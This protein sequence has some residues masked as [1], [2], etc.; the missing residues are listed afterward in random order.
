MAHQLDADDDGRSAKFNVARYLEITGQLSAQLLSTA[1]Q[2]G[3]ASAD[4]I[5]AKFSVNHD[6]QLPRQLFSA[7][8]P[9]DLELIDLRP[10]AEQ[11]NANPLAAAEKLMAADLAVPV[12]LTEDVLYRQLLIRLADDHWIWYQ[13]FH[14]M[15]L[16]G[17]SFTTLTGRICGIYR[18]LADGR[19]PT[20]SA[21][22]SFA[23]LVAA[24][25]EYRGSADEEADATFWRNYCTGLPAPL[26]VA[27]VLGLSGTTTNET[28]SHK[29][30]L[31]LSQDAAARLDSLA[32]SNRLNWT[33]LLSAAIAEFLARMADQA[34]IV[35]GV[36]MMG[37]IGRTATERAALRST[38]PVVTV[39]PLRLAMTD[40]SLPSRA[41]E[42]AL[43][44][45]GIKNHWR[46][47]SEQ[48]QRDAGLTG[49]AD[50]GLYGPVL[51]LKIFDYQVDFGTATGKTHHLSAGPIEELE[52][53]IY[54][55]DGQIE[56][57][58]EA[59]GSKYSALDTQNLAERLS[60]WLES[61]AAGN[62]QF[63]SPEEATQLTVW[64][65]GAARS[66]EL[67][68]VV[69]LFAQ[70]ARTSHA[71]PALSAAG[72]TLTFG[73]LAERANKLARVLIARGVGAESVVAVALPR[74]VDSVVSIMAVHA[75]G[76]AILPLDLE[77]PSDRLGY[78]LDDAAPVALISTSSVELPFAG[79]RIDLDALNFAILNGQEIQPEERLSP[80]LPEHLAYV[81]YTSG[82]TGKP[83]GVLSTH[84]GLRNLLEHHRHDQYERTAAAL[85]SGAQNR[86][87]R[88]LH[89]ASMSFDSAWDQLL[90]LYLGHEVFICDDESRR[91][92]AALV[93]LIRAERLDSL[94]VTP[95]F[96]SQLID[97]GL[98]ERGEHHPALVAFGGEAASPSIWAALR[99]QAD[100]GTH[101]HNYYGPTEYSVDS[102]GAGVEQADEPVVGLPLSNTD[103]YVLDRK[104]RAV[105][106]GVP[107]E[108][109]IAGPGLA[110]GYH[111][112]FG[113]TA[114]RFIANPF[115]AEPGSRMYR[116]GD[117]ARWRA[118][119]L[120]DYLSRADDQ[121]KIRG[122]RVEPG[123]VEAAIDAL[124]GILSA[125]V[126]AEKTGS[127][128]RLVGFAVLANAELAGDSIR[129]AL[130][131][132]L[133][134]YLIP[135]V[136]HVIDSM[137]LTVNGKIDRAALPA[138]AV[139]AAPTQSRAA[140]GRAAAN[141]Q[142]AMLCQAVSD[143]VRI[144]QVSPDDD[145]FALG[146][147]SISAMSL[148]GAARR[149]G[150]LL[151]PRQ[152]FELRTAA[153]M[154]VELQPLPDRQPSIPAAGDTPVL[155]I[156]AWYLEELVEAVYAQG[157]CLAVPEEATPELLGQ[158]LDAVRTA[159]PALAASLANGILQVPEQVTPLVVHPVS[160]AQDPA[161]T[162]R[163][164]AEQLDPASGRMLAA[165]LLSGS[166]NG[167]SS[168]MLLLAAHHLVVDGVSWRVILPELEAAY[169]ALLA[170]TTP[171][172]AA[173][174]TSLRAWSAELRSQDHQAELPFWHTQ[175]QTPAGS[176]GRIDARI[177]RHG[178]AGQQRILL[179]SAS[180]AALL[181]MVPARFNCTVDESLLAAV[182]MAMRQLR[183]VDSL[184]L[185]RETHGRHA[186]LDLERT[187]GWLTSE[188]P[189]HLPLA[190]DPRDAV[191][192]VK[193]AIR[194]V[195]A[196]GL[197]WGLLR[198]GGTGEELAQLQ[199]NNPASLL[200]NYLGRFDSAAAGSE[201][202]FQP[203][204]GIF[205]DAFAVHL[206]PAAPLQHP[207]ELNAFL[208]ESGPEAQL[209]LSWTW[210]SGLL[211]EADITALSAG[212]ALAAQQLLAEK[213]PELSFVP[214]D[215]AVPV[216][217]AQVQQLEQR[218]G[219]L[220][221]VLPLT[222]LHEGLLYQSSVE[223]S[224][225]ASVTVLELSGE[226][227]ADRLKA[228]LHQVLHRYPQLGAV[229]STELDQLAQIIPADPGEISWQV[230]TGQETDLAALEA[231]ETDRHF[232]PSSGPLLAATLL[233]TEVSHAF[234]LLTTHHLL[235]DGWSTPIIVEALLAAYRDDLPAGNGLPDYA[236]ALA[237]V[238]VTDTDRQAWA[239]ALDD[240]TPTMV[241][242]ETTSPVD[243]LPVAELSVRLPEELYTDLIA[244]ARER[245][246]TMNAIAQLGFAAAL[247]TLSG[248]L[249][250][251]FG[252]TVSGRDADNAA[253]KVVG[254]FTNTVPVRIAV[255]A[256]APLAAQLTR[257]QGEQ[258][259]LRD[260]S[261]LGLADIQALGGAGTLFDTLFVME[262][263]PD[264]P[265]S[266]ST[267]L[268]LTSV[269]NRGYTHYPLTVLMLPETN[270]FRLVIEYRA[271]VLD[272][273]GFADRFMAALRILATDSAAGIG[274]LETLSP[275]QRNE[276]AAFNDTTHALPES[277]LRE[278]LR[279]QA[280]RTPA[281][282][283]LHDD[284]IS[285]S[286][287]QLRSRVQVLAARLQAAGARPGNV[288]AVALP[289]SAQLSI[290]ILAVIES[291][292][293]YLPLD[294][295]Y[296]EER[297]RYMLDDAKPVAVIGTQQVQHLLSQDT[298]W[299]DPALA[300]ISPVT[301]VLDYP[302]TGAD[303][304]Y[305]IYT[306]GSTGKPKGVLVPHQAIV[307]RL[308]W[309]Q[310]H[311]P[312]TAEDLV[313]QKTPSSFDVSVWE[314][315]WPFIVGARQFSA[316]PEAH[317]DPAAIASTIA[318]HAVSTLH[319]VPS[320]LAAFV[321]YF[322]EPASDAI[323][324]SSLRQV[325]CSGEALPTELAA[326]WYRLGGAPLHNLYGPTEAAVDVSYQ[327]ATGTEL[328]SS[329]PI[330]RPVWNT[331]LHVLDAALRQVAPGVAGELYLAGVQL[332]I[333]YAGR[334]DL[335]AGRFVADPMGEPGSRMYRTGDVVRRLADGTIEYLGRS[336]DQ[337]KIR[338]Q[339][340]EL[341]EISA[342]LAEQ[343]G[344][345]RAVVVARSLADPDDHQAR[346]GGD[347]RQ[348]VGYVVGDVDA[349]L[350]L[351]AAAR[352]LP[353]HLVPVALVVL[354]A[355]PLS[356]NGKLDY[357]AL[358]TPV[359]AA[360]TAGT[361][362]TTG[363]PPAAGLERVIAQAFEQVLALPEGSFSA[364]ESFFTRGGHSLLAMRVVAQLRRTAQSAAVSV[365]QIMANPT[366]ELLAASLS[367]DNAID[368]GFGAKLQIK[369]SVNG[370]YLFCIHPASGFAWQYQA[371]SRYLAERTEL[372]GMGIVGLQSTRPDG[373]LATC[374]SMAEVVEDE[375]ARILEIQPEGPY[376]LLGYSLGGTIAQAVAA[377][378]VQH[379]A[380]VSF[381]GLLDTYPPEG[382]D[383]AAPEEDEAQHEVERERDAFLADPATSAEQEK[384][385]GDIVANYADAIRLLSC[386]RSAHFPG[387]ADLFVATGTLPADVVPEVVWAPHL[388]G[389]RSYPLDCAHEDIMAPKNL[390]QLGPLLAKALV[391]ALKPD[392]GSKS[393]EDK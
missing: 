156:S 34:E 5:L 377:R 205:A 310:Y 280:L 65:T 364:T 256:A 217:A 370:Q 47:G 159:H 341:G 158:A 123:E 194:S 337:V 326:A 184:L 202:F 179:D 339:R 1:V 49:L 82:S 334:P 286:Y 259:A 52:F 61:S 26:S 361:A 350:L 4:T 107:G 178:A 353:P 136:I 372:Q 117:L 78:M 165:V 308:L 92:P 106:I 168:K 131:S 113:L 71:L 219:A 63:L 316:H 27:N 72:I 263:Y 198:Y 42:F 314:F 247:S 43:A 170:G 60:V 171:K 175:L 384:M 25:A 188:F 160:S 392:A 257:I 312:L 298:V 327:A 140:Q 357:R 180:T 116:T 386:A 150:F 97:A 29:A 91:D 296:P 349:E 281:A 273:P 294:T 10:A 31:T 213:Q 282:P 238:T 86:R 130:A 193:E 253:A 77:Y 340:I 311:Y 260:H 284:S 303:P 2:R 229:F 220:Q 336:D 378:L 64:G 122:F 228:A 190:A 390:P 183:G 103:A 212:L 343:A 379:G 199:R 105:P 132:D 258:A 90:W 104:L 329:V 182:G 342:V 93:E 164:A 76:G 137:P 21:V 187:V 272:G 176:L 215:S 233:R 196:D 389:L 108:L 208:D 24:E 173:E 335:T 333:G 62:A 380:Q 348:L 301:S 383:W 276:F 125:A 278:L 152:V 359:A 232:D 143:L 381:L 227:D 287:A 75:A 85:L 119:G 242:C 38:G 100:S 16:D 244:T 74:S 317:R 338:G 252:T 344:V 291:G 320:M 133:P 22:T 375:L 262:N 201:S 216:T 28:A 99:A 41:A 96:L 309:M 385:F 347:N 155:P 318:K 153:A 81:I 254:L 352:K 367:S 330:G 110:R 9:A 207:L 162:F 230:L 73:Q 145:F 70:Q 197:G 249:D 19:T 94:D 134:D 127:T 157:V 7:H 274:S 167:Q 58:I 210:A 269:R 177:H 57:E 246:V 313:L 46:Y 30:A 189:L 248:Q 237:A 146:G 163:A 79:P 295:S 362:G 55:K 354:P 148:C 321:E 265:A 293:A 101:G 267:G 299:L 87:P 111:R 23:E 371:L 204:S 139:Q 243:Q 307:N 366:A 12:S 95:S 51:N 285:L 144:P 59:P 328:T 315:F 141:A 39:L 355:L 142:E 323:A 363:R 124:D 368:H 6:D 98:F 115:S 121:V 36:P 264:E 35:L 53:S 271:E 56:C 221:A 345:E 322:E 20:E 109:Y 147:D 236:R 69:E 223:G 302:L 112:R 66:V 126:I 235:L 393:V 239:N 68:T 304:A 268:S 374:A 275:K 211:T 360:S 191:R 209:A 290:A 186:E 325:F 373:V 261:A 50:D 300:A 13:R 245:G 129:A 391:T 356:A 226:L 297:L 102:L 169:K 255:D 331:R 382:Q 250:V 114:S 251:V 54:R 32:R 138:L 48:I 283:A 161:A 225:Y 154:A 224:G 288:V 234:L 214:A 174:Q 149:A 231:A 14:H 120:L 80:V 222:P 387:T 270:G 128:H 388:H 305:L 44:M 83:K 37:R 319:F 266:A 89:T 200:V 118:D 185:S 346:S 45:S 40:E 192:A 241:G 166:N 15:L 218:Y 181:D 18:D 172:L 67:P 365:G 33:D 8:K 289:R 195:P 306:S 279:G 240:V 376:A 351:A 292:A 206:D 324:L 135:A 203:L 151:R 369:P 17:Y 332:A 358:P 11:P 277:T 84:R 3:L 88:A